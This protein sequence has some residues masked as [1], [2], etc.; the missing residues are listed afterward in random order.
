MDRVVVYS[1]GVVANDAS[2]LPSGFV[3]RT[4]ANKKKGATTNLGILGGHRLV[5]KWIGTMSIVKCIV[6]VA[7]R[8]NCARRRWKE[9][10][11]ETIRQLNIFI[12][13][14]YFHLLS[15][16]AL[17]GFL[18]ILTSDGEVFFATHTIESYL[19]FHQVKKKTNFHC[20]LRLSR[21]CPVE[22][23]AREMMGVGSTKLIS[24]VMRLSRA[25]YYLFCRKG[26]RQQ[27][28]QQHFLYID[29]H[30]QTV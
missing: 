26:R 6:C 29:R 13:S 17:N 28:Q 21:R 19:G 10:P 18:L 30:Y 4:D 20:F 23:A 11:H 16:Q 22:A 1:P 3:Q 14:L 2:T 24:C 25:L 7:L 9:R 5:C 15:L 12:P 27:Q 8:R